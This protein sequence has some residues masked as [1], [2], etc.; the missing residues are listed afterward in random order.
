RKGKS[1]RRGEGALAGLGSTKLVSTK[2]DQRGDSSAPA[3]AAMCQGLSYTGSAPP[4]WQAALHPW[5]HSCAPPGRS[6]VAAARARRTDHLE[7]DWRVKPSFRG[8][9]N[10]TAGDQP[11]GGAHPPAHAYVDPERMTFAQWNQRWGSE[12]TAVDRN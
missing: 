8:N 4:A 5:L 11:S 7:I 3:G 6:D 10:Y 9:S 2:L 1:P 12:R